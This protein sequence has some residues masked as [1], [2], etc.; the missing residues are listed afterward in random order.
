MLE[1]MK[2]FHKTYEMVKWLHTLLNKFPKSEKWTLG[3]KIENTGLNVMEGVIQ[4]NNEFDKTKALQYT[5]V[6]LDKLRIY[7]RLAKDFQFISTQQYEY[8]SKLVNEI[9]RMLGGWYK[10]FA[11]RGGVKLTRFL[12]KMVL[13]SRDWAGLR[14]DCGRAVIRGGNWDNGANAGPFYANLNNEPSNV[15]PNIGFRCCSTL[16]VRSFISAKILDSTRRVHQFNPKFLPNME[17]L[18]IKPMGERLVA[19]SNPAFPFYGDMK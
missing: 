5:I 11:V 6:E 1:D 12:I 14:Y 13:S 2:I 4:S 16:Q 18:N 15:N 9:G 17:E 10:K 8:A 19:V 7:F 3:Q